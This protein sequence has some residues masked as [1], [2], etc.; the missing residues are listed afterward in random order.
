MRRGQE[1]AAL[2]SAGAALGALG[3]LAFAVVFWLAVE[4]SVLGA[5]AGASVAWLI[6][7]VAAWHARRKIRDVRQPREAQKSTTLRSRKAADR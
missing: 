7:S 2:D 3:M 4:K 6:V 5:F 1:A